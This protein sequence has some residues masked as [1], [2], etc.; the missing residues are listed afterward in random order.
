[1]RGKSVVYLCAL[2]GS[3][4]ALT[5]GGVGNQ[6]HASV[7]NIAMENQ[8][9][10]N[11]PAG[12]SGT[13]DL[14][15]SA[16]TAGLTL[17]GVDLPIKVDP[18]ELG[19]GPLLLT[20][21]VT[22]PFTWFV[23]PDMDVSDSINGNYFLAAVQ[24]FSSIPVPTTP[25]VLFTLNYT[26]APNVFDDFAIM[27]E[28]QSG[29]FAVLSNATSVVVTDGSVTTV[30]EPASMALLMAGGLLTIITRRR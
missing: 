2:A 16:D 1:M 22:S 28:E 3:L 30:P 19:G 25:S 18:S 5:C 13:L 27:I 9:V 7:I 4:S 14:V 15:F 12:V 21:T 11:G 6:V 10:F 23:G 24:F 26:V 17:E 29:D 8:V 20:S